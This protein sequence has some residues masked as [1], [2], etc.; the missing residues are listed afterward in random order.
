[1]SEKRRSEESL[2]EQLARGYRETAERAAALNEEWKHVSIEATEHL[3]PTPAWN[4][5]T[6][7]IALGYVC[8]VV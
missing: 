3:G 7:C 5:Q 2:E 8:S 1:M 4:S 6:D